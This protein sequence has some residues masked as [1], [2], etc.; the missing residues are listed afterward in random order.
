MIADYYDQTARIDRLET[1]TGNKK[2]FTTHIE[3]L[4]CHIQ[5]LDPQ[6]TGDIEG[7][8]G[9]NF[10]MFSESAD[11]REGDRVFIDDKEYR[12]TSTENLSF[13]GNSHQE[14]I[15]RIFD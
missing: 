7:G 12:I 3:S 15:I 14:T 9:K 13:R 2:S 4:R 5:P 8:F 10:L 11:I 1:T 6:I